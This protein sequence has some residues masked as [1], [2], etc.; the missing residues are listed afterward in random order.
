MPLSQLQHSS[1]LLFWADPQK[2]GIRI[3]NDKHFLASATKTE[4]LY[5][6]R[7][8]RKAGNNPIQNLRSSCRVI[9]IVSAVKKS[10]CIVQFLQI[11]NITG[12]NNNDCS[13]HTNKLGCE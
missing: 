3:P 2:D 7:T 4:G 12:L 5:S 1:G 8:T 9:G 13:L 6:F 10:L 11:D